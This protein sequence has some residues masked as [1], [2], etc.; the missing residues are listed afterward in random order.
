[1]ADLT[2]SHESVV[3]AF[4]RIGDR[5]LADG[6]Q[7]DI[8]PLLNHLQAAVHHLLGVPGQTYDPSR[9]DWA[10]IINTNGDIYPHADAYSHE[11]W[12][13]N[14]FSQSFSDIL[15]LAR[16]GRLNSRAAP[17]VGDLSRL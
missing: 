8:F 6:L 5:W 12:M 3:D 13:G 14:A 10:Y 11:G 7:I 2:L 9:G 17:T 4:K 15:D 1:M 16:A